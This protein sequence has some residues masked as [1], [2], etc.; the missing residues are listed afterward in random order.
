[1]PPPRI[2]LSYLKHP[3][4]QSCLLDLIPA[5]SVSARYFSSST[6]IKPVSYPSKPSDESEANANANAPQNDAALKQEI[7]VWSREEARYVKD[8][9]AISPV[10]YA[11]K[12]APLPEDKAE[13]EISG[14]VDEQLKRESR[15]IEASARV[16]RA[17]LIQQEEENVPF[18]TLIKPEKKRSKVALDIHEA[19]REVKVDLSLE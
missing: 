19:I 11:P 6:P 10:S 12:V 7:P 14:E 1:M 3:S 18:P 13:A 17:M 4:H 2:I 16:R 9:Q 8:F 15:K 5:I